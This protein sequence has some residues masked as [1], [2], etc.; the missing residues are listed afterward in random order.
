MEQ[1]QGPVHYLPSIHHKSVSGRSPREPAPPPFG[2]PHLTSRSAAT[3]AGR[4][5]SLRE[6]D[7]NGL[8]RS[9]AHVRNALKTTNDLDRIS[10]QLNEVNISYNEVIW[11]IAICTVFVSTAS[12]EFKGRPKKDGVI[13][14]SI[15]IP[16]CFRGDS[17]DKWN[18]LTTIERDTSKLW[19]PS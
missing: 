16:W 14:S 4:Y 18:I 1:T 8:Q 6:F 19:Y 7:R 2:L 12:Q 5:R 3:K 15:R 17:E 13:W 10:R 9:K 11:T